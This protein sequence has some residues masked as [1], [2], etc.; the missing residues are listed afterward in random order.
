MTDIRATATGVWSNA[1]I[2]NGG[3]VPTTGDSAFSN[4]FVITIDQDFT[5]NVISNAAGGGGVAGGG[6]VLNSGRTITANVIGGWSNATFNTACLRFGLA[7]PGVA[8]VV[9]HVISGQGNNLR[10]L[11]ITANGTLNIVGGVSCRSTALGVNANAACITNV[12]GDITGGTSGD[13]FSVTL[14]G[15]VG[16]TLN[17]TGNVYGGSAT[18]RAINAQVNGSISVTGFCDPGATGA[19]QAISATGA[20]T[21]LRV[22][23]DIKAGPY[24]HGISMT[25]ATAF[26]NVTGAIFA[27]ASYNGLF[28]SG[29]SSI[30][31]ITGPCYNGTGTLN[32]S[33][34]AVVSSAVQLT[35]TANGMIWGF[36]ANDDITP[37]NLYYANGLPN[38]PAVDDVRDG[39]IYGSGG[40]LEGTMVVP[41]AGEVSFGVNYDN[42]G[43][44]GTAVLTQQD[45]ADAVGVLLEALGP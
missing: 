34:M 37:V 32:Y 3:V 24:A 8:N 26:A 15:G 33:R 10:A 29:A 20:N 18:G 5:C 21:V 36:Y 1:S 2:W 28:M 12:T 6:F 16:F 23:G 39:V 38:L 44:T 40:A 31:H 45:V 4:L 43:T 35:P 19:G 25:G 42:N 14:A 7:S 17:V 41:A 22:V 11:D 30:A 27:S 9:G 13:A